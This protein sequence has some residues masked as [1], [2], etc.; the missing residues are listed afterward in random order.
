MTA[1][2]TG[3]DISSS[4][5]AHARKLCADL[6]TEPRFMSGNYLNDPLPPDQ[7]L[8]LL[9][10]ADYCALSPQQRAHLLA[11]MRGQL[12]A[13]G[14][15]I[16]DVFSDLIFSQLSESLTIEPNLMGGFW[17]PA[18]YVGLQR[19]W[20]WP[21]SMLALDHYLIANENE[22]F[23]IYNWMQYFSPEDLRQEFARFGFEKVQMIDILTGEALGDEQPR[24]FAAILSL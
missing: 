14:H 4:S 24:E 19:S 11:K 20:L 1:K 2:V 21:E 23:E 9:I 16:L 7:D 15:I 5:L 8:V 3:F 22:Q 10:Y 17:A 18:P 13:G 12:R 6:D